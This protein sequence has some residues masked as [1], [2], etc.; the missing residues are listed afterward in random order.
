MMRVTWRGV[1]R[2]LALTRPAY[3]ALIPMGD[4][5]S[6]AQRTVRERLAAGLI[7]A[8]TAEATLALIREAESVLH[9]RPVVDYHDT[10]DWTPC[11][12]GYVRKRHGIGEGSQ[13]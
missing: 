5:P 9:R 3:A 11:G 4:C 1:L 6:R 2:R 7:D 12:C 13:S 10:D 8:D